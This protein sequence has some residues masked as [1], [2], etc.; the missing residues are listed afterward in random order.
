MLDLAI[1]SV[2]KI[3]EL[4]WQEAL[5]EYLKRLKPFCKISFLEVPEEKITSVTDRKRI[6]EAEG[7]RIDKQLSNDTY[8]VVLDKVG[9]NV[10]SEEFAKKLE[11]WS[12]FGKRITFIIGG[13]LGLSPKIMTRAKVSISLSHMTFTH[14]MTRVILMEQ[15]YRAVS[16]LQGKAYHY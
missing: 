15:I 14:Q 8:I 5:A 13:P 10:S 12:Y 6:L 4:Y 9:I 16:I 3:K 7:D 2:G 1:I 11:G